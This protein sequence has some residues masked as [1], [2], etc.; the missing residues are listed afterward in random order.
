MVRTS[1]GCPEQCAHCGA[2]PNGFLNSDL[3]VFEVPPDELTHMLMHSID[4]SEKRIKDWL[5]SDITTDVN[6][7]PL[8]TKKFTDF[9]Q[10][11]HDITQGNSRVIT[12]S[13]GVRQGI[14][15]MRDRLESIIDLMRRDIVRNFILTMDLQRLKGD[16][17]PRKNEDSYTETLECMRPAFSFPNTRITVSLQGTASPEHPKSIALVEEMY[18]RIRRRLLE[19][20]GWS[21][22][23][24]QRIHEDHR[25]SY[26]KIGRAYTM[27]SSV[28]NEHCEIIPDE[29]LIRHIRR[30]GIPKYRGRIDGFR[31]VLEA[32]PLRP[33]MTYGDTVDPKRWETVFQ[34]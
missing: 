25:G 17:D 22:E 13:H 33:G 32:Q 27:V 9:A 23:T 19:E 29:T 20:L 7:E 24:L 31:K 2:Y 16:I 15:T 4:G 18:S 8:Q 30:K 21:E 10:L 26:T 14:R 6:T 11:I 34:F 1:Q 5:A 3:R 28:E 12:I